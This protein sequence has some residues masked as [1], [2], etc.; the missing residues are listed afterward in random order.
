MYDVEAGDHRSTRRTTD[1]RQSPEKNF[2]IYNNGAVLL[3]GNVPNST[4]SMFARFTEERESA[5]RKF[6]LQLPER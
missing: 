2:S 5:T 4:D 3:G 1:T 6:G